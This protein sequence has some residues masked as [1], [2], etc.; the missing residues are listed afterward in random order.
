MKRGIVASS[1]ARRAANIKSLKLRDMKSTAGT[2]RHVGPHAFGVKSGTAR[3]SN[4]NQV[5]CT[6]LQCSQSS[7]EG[8]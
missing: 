8:L 7:E 3:A 6:H 5:P 2:L 4:I 1:V